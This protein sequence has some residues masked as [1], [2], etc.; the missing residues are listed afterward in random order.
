MT[1][2]VGCPQ[3]G[4]KYQFDASAIPAE[5]YDAQCTGCGGVFFVAPEK[6]PDEQISVAC[7]HCGAVYQFPAS[8]I[9]AE[10]YDAQCTQCQQVFFVSA[11]SEQPEFQPTTPIA[12]PDPETV[13]PPA[14]SVA[15]PAVSTEPASQPSAPVPQPPEM[16]APGDPPTEPA[17]EAPVTQSTEP[18][19]TALPE[20]PTPL[21]DLK[22][23]PSEPV[24]LDASRSPLE[25]QPEPA[26]EPPDE[27]PA[28]DMLAMANDLGEPDE[29]PDGVSLEEDFEAIVR[30]RRRRRIVVLALLAVLLGY[31]L[32]TYE[33]APRVFDQ[34]V[35]R[36][37]RV[38]L[39]VDPAAI[40]HAKKGLERMLDDTDAA[41][42]EAVVEL[43]EALAID[44]QYP[45]AIAYKGLA[46]LFRGSD[47][48]ARGR[49]IREQGQSA[50]N[51]IKALEA[52]PAESR[53]TDID[54]RLAELR[55]RASEAD[56]ESAKL[57]E[58]GGKTVR[59]GYALLRD[60]LEEYED[61]PLVVEAAGIY[62]TTD[63]DS[64]PRA[65]KL[66]RHSLGLRYG[67]D[68]ELDLAAPPNHWLPY[69]QGL[70]RASEKNGEKAARDAFAAAVAK[71]PRFQR[72]RFQLA[73]FNENKNAPAEADR[74]AQEILAQVPGHEKATVLLAR[75]ASK[76]EEPAPTPSVTRGKAKGK[77]KGKG[78]GKRKG[79]RKRR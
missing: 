76:V 21:T 25:P 47:I 73:L 48:Q 18:S 20:E 39:T 8:A 2:E 51:E 79:K 53:P 26:P 31:S 68:E 16:G 54:Q 57:F 46:Q 62:Y 24:A 5:G 58:K 60:G 10:G 44:S 75:H 19:A 43:D 28:G 23:S 70:V 69:L 78:K 15:T 7:K 61:D 11:T 4:A 29:S 32:V 38:K 22:A 59:E 50:I 41:Y 33:L 36:V 71:E 42:R 66:L 65:A 52:L 77:G 37:V 67:P 3:C 49:A 56:R 14:E 30:R 64:L 1:M 74:L 63:S 13:T 27:G 12:Q 17:S 72:A 35:G 34:T 40:P 6:P 9:P 55:S 45:A